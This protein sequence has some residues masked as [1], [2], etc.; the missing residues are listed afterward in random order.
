[1]IRPECYETTPKFWT[2]LTLIEPHK[3]FSIRLLLMLKTMSG[4]LSPKGH[5]PKIVKDD[6]L[7]ESCSRQSRS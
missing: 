5:G 6:D 4:V 2:Q 1:M 3:P 7:E